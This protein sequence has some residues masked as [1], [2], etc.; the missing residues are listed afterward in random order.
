MCCRIVIVLILL[1]TTNLYAGKRNIHPNWAPKTWMLRPDD[2][3]TIMGYRAEL[4]GNLTHA[5]RS[6][7][8][9]VKD[10]SVRGFINENDIMTWEVEVPYEAEYAV[11]LL[12][13]GSKEIDGYRQDMPVSGASPKVEVVVDDVDSSGRWVTDT[14][15]HSIGQVIGN[16]MLPAHTHFLFRSNG[17]D[18]VS[19]YFKGEKGWLWLNGF[20]LREQMPSG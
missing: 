19:I 14:L 10:A 12:Y 2:I 13:R 3:T 15:G 8:E 6:G 20:E 5:D 18:P 7:P 1:A 9:I 11:A 17:R 4:T 16:A